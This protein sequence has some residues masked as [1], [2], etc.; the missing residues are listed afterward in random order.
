M[1]TELHPQR[2][3]R[4]HAFQFIV[5]Y[6]HHKTFIALQNLTGTSLWNEDM[7]AVC[8]HER[9]SL[10]ALPSRNLKIGGDK[11]LGNGERHAQLNAKLVLTDMLC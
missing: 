8:E 3:Q 6:D 2:L 10:T 11:H 4:Y 1:I 9:K 7:N 5:E